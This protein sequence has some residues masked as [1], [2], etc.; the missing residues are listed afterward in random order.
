M[1]GEC[2][3]NYLTTGITFLGVL[4]AVI[5]IYFALNQ[6]KQEKRFKKAAFFI[7]LRRTFKENTEFTKIRELLEQNEE[8]TSISKIKKYDYAGFFEELQIAINSEFISE[9]MVYYLFGYYI[10]QFDTA[11]GVERD[12]PLWAVF[13]TLAEKMKSLQRTYNYDNNLKF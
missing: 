7:E 10:I 6:Y 5:S 13:K 8:L 9:E 4:I 12:A 1:N 2:I 11:K 3:A